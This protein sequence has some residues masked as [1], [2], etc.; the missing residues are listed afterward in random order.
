M[1]PDRPA[2]KV[3][4]DLLVPPVLKD[5]Q[6]LPAGQVRQVLRGN[7][8]HLALL[9]PPAHKAPQVFKDQRVLRDQPVRQDFKVYQE[10][11]VQQDLPVLLVLKV[12]L[13][14]LDPPAHK[15]PQD[16]LANRVLQALLEPL[17]PQARQ[18]LLARQV[19]KGFKVHL[20]LQDLQD[21]RDLQGFK[22]HPE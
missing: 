8:V 3:L 19:P 5:P 17:A 10:S 13:A 6:A 1:Q 20:G 11:P 2:H 22:V 4:R 15:A 16:P 12:L 9:E 21:Q 7:K 14:L 18:V